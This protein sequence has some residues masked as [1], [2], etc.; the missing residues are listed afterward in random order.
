[1]NIIKDPHEISPHD[2]SIPSFL[3]I[4]MFL[5]SQPQKYF[6]HKGN[7]FLFHFLLTPLA[8]LGRLFSFQIHWETHTYAYPLRQ[9]ERKMSYLPK[10]E[11]RKANNFLSLICCCC[12]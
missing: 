5:F 8:V 11:K 10:V 9:A 3:S 12:C 1:M 2:W 6:P 4:K 7:V